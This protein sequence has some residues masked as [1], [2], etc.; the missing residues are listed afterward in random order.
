[1]PV[2]QL[3]KNSFFLQFCCTPTGRRQIPYALCY[4]PVIPGGCNPVRKLVAFRGVIQFRCAEDCPFGIAHCPFS[5]ASEKPFSHRGFGAGQCDCAIERMN[6]IQILEKPRRRGRN[7]RNAVSA[8]AQMPIN[9]H[10]SSRPRAP[11]EGAP[12]C[13]TTSNQIPLAG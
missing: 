3:N 6:D 4:Q 8:H 2:I 13:L 12:G 9:N 1:V 11:G 10:W 7:G 5:P